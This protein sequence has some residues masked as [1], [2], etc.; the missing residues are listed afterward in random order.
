MT[1]PIVFCPTCREPMASIADCTWRC[2]YC[3]HV[4]IR[5]VRNG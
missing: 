1:A 3:G 5:E 2:R 4:E